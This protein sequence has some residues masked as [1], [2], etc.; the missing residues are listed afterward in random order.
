MAA[1]TKSIDPAARR[2]FAVGCWSALFL[3]DAVLIARRLTGAMLPGAATP[4]IV[5]SLVIVATAATLAWL[6]FVSSPALPRTRRQ[7]AGGM[8]ILVT[9]SWAAPLVFPISPLGAGMVVGILAAQLLFIGQAELRDLADRV[10]GHA[11]PTAP[12]KPP[13]FAASPPLDVPPGRANPDV[14]E[15]HFAATAADEGDE[16][17]EPDEEAAEGAADGQTQWISRY[18]GDDGERIEG[19][20]Q[21]SFASG[22]RETTVHLSFCPA[23]PGPADIETEDLDGIGLEIRIAAL[24]PF[25]ARLSVRRSGAITLADTVRVGF[26]V[27]ITRRSA[28]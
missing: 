2:A 9:W 14:D 13:P 19:W 27:Q 23:L 26:L 22:Q 17:D 1:R 10:C 12:L 21:A 25:G 7:L 20:T 15:S 24:F 18:S 3:A 4:L 5:G 8:T 28:A 6:L 16:P 11:S